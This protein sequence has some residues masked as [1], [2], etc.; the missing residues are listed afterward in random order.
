MDPQAES[1]EMQDVGGRIKSTSIKDEARLNRN[2]FKNLYEEIRMSS[3]VT[4]E[5]TRKK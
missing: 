3:V 4:T 2:M 1:S 5:R